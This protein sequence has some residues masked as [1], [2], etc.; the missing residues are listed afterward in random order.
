[1]TVILMQR[2]LDWHHSATEQK[3]E[4]Y[5]QDASQ[6]EWIPNTDVS[7]RAEADNAIRFRTVFDISDF[8]LQRQSGYVRIAE[9]EQTLC[10]ER[11]Y[12]AS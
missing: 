10:T 4:T 1:M 7:V 6:I 9:R 12:N 2:L 3:K 8:F 5:R 11:E